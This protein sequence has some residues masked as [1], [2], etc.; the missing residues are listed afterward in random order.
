MRDIQQEVVVITGATA[1]VGRA[2]VRAFA[3]RG[4]R[5]GLIARGVD[6]LK[7]TAC[8][9]EALGG[10]A[11]A[12]SCD[13]ADAATVEDAANEVEATFGPIDIWINAAFAGV[14][15]PF[16]RMS[17]QDYKRVTEVTYLG[18]VHGTMAALKRMLPRN[19]GSIVLVGSALAYRGIP[20]QSAYCGA[21]HAIQGFQDSLRSELIHAGSKVH[22][23]MVQLP[24]VNT[25]QFD[26]I[27][28]TMPC[29]PKPASP[30]YQPEVA[31]DAIYFAAHSHR[32]SVMVGFPTVEAIWGDRLFSSLL[33]HYLGWTGFKG[34]QD[35]EKL[36]PGRQ[37]NLYHP[38]P[39]D[40]G[41][42]GRFDRI[43]RTRSWQLSL[44]KNRLLF[45]MG[46]VLFVAACRRALK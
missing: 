1:G 34:Q 26:W 35:R 22:L 29:K 19:R 23:S 25:P 14:L 9:V 24:G 5:I 43:A 17:L 16:L 31:A 39:G 21:K 37:N 7:A 40:H 38:V 45:G 15:A 36:E 41:A 28:T 44:N 20:L 3:R 2:T 46:L 12:I 30:P 42:H 32:K 33:D 6:G 8:E 18:Q 4:A 13:V 10:E 27:K 11:V